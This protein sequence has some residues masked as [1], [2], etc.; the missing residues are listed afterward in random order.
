[1]KSFWIALSFLTVLPVPYIRFSRE[2]GELSASAAFFP[3]VGALVGLLLALVAAGL[4]QLVNPGSAVVIV[5]AFSFFLTRGMHLDGLADVADGLVGTTD[6]EKARAAMKDSSVGVMGLAVVLL[7]FLFKYS[8][9]PALEAREIILYVAA[10]PVVGRWA[11]VLVGASFNPAP[12]RGLG[13]MFLEELGWP[14]LLQ[15]TFFFLLLMGGL[16]CAEP[17]L[18]KPVLAGL[19]LAL[20]GVYALAI[21]AA[22]RLGGLTGDVMGAVNELAEVLFLLG[23]IAVLQ[24]PAGVNVL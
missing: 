1:V 3:V 23:V 2:R 6:R 21:W 15:A 20:A 13:E 12:R 9:L 8:A 18:T 10:M 19:G 16:V 7:L 22:R 4:L 24:T 14:G 17:A 11:I 5:L